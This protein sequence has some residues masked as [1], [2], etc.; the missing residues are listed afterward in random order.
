MDTLLSKRPYLE[1]A[2]FDMCTIST[3]INM[4]LS[5]KNS[6][7]LNK[8]SHLVLLVLRDTAVIIL[9]FPNIVIWERMPLVKEANTMTCSHRHT[10]QEHVCQ[11]SLTLVQKWICCA[12]IGIL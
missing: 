4:S 1:S 7:D 12:R 10:S 5:L 11:I 6:E 3:F 8:I 2:I 9:S